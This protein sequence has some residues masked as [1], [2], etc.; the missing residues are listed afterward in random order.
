MSWFVLCCVVFALDCFSAATKEAKLLLQL[1][2][3]RSWYCGYHVDND[4]IML[5][6]LLLL[7]FLDDEFGLDDGDDDDDRL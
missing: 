7:L 2:P 4:D 5:L 6:L 1:R 3:S